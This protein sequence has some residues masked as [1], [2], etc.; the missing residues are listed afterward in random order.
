MFLMEKYQNGNI[1]VKR[2]FKQLLMVVDCLHYFIIKMA[3]KSI[4]SL[5]SLEYGY[6]YKVFMIY[7]STFYLLN[8]Y[9]INLDMGVV[10]YEFTRIHNQ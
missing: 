7:S 4:K 1:L 9:K 5:K 8:Y 2:R 3:T 10:N 6:C